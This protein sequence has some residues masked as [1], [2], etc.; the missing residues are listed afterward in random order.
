VRGGIFVATAVAQE[1][2]VGFD[3]IAL[4]NT[5]LSS[6]VRDALRVTEIMYNP[7]S[8]DTVE[9]I[10]LQNTGLAAI[11]L[12][13]VRFDEG[14]PVDGMV[15]GK[16]T[17]EP[18]E[19]I[20][21]T[22]D[23]AAFRTRYGNNARLGG[24]W[25][26]GS[27]SNSGERVLLRDA[28]GNTIHDFTYTDTAPWPASADGTG[29]SLEFVDTAGNY[30]NP[31]SWSGSLRLTGT[32]GK[33]GTS[34]APVAVDDTL[35]QP[36][37]ETGALLDVLANDTDADGDPLVITEVA[38]AASGTVSLDG[39]K[40]R[41]EPGPT[42]T[43]SDTFTYKINDGAGGVATATVTLQNTA[44]SAVADFLH[45]AW[46][47]GGIVLNVVGND[48]DPDGDQRTITAV[49]GATNGSTTTDGSTVTYTP[50]AAFSGSDSFTYTISDGHGGVATAL[51]TL[52][53]A[54]PVAA[55]DN[56]TAGSAAVTVAVL[57]ND[58]DADGDTL[59]LT[60]VTQGANGT[61]AIEGTGVV[62]TPGANFQGD[63]TFT[64]NVSD[65]HGGIA[66]GTVNVR[67]GGLITQTAAETGSQVPGAAPGTTYASLQVPAVGDEG[68][69]AWVSRVRTPGSKK[70]KTMLIGGDPVRALF[71]QGDQVP[72]LPGGTTFASFQAPVCDDEGRVV[73]MAGLAGAGVGKKDRAAI[74][75]TEPGGVTTMVA[76]LGT[77]ATGIAGAT[78][79]SFIALDASGGE[80]L[81]V[82]KT[83]GSTRTG[84]WAW[85]GQTTRLV[86]ST[87]VQITTSGGSKTVSAVSLL[88]AVPGSPG[89]DRSHRGGQV[90]LRLTFS[91]KS[92]A[93]GHAKLDGEQWTLALQAMSSQDT[94]F[95]GTWKSFGPPALGAA[96]STAA[97]GQVAN[98][99]AATTTALAVF[100]QDGSAEV[101]RAGDPATA[102]TTMVSFADPVANT[103]GAIAFTAKVSGAGIS[104]TK[105]TRLFVV[106]PGGEMTM[107]AAQG[108]P[109]GAGAGT[110][111]QK[112]V[113]YALPEGTNSEPIFLATFTGPG[114]TK[115]NNLGL[116]TRKSDGSYLMIAR[117][118]QPATGLTSAKVIKKLTLLNALPPVPG[119]A[120][121]FNA[122]RSVAYLATF[123]DGTQAVQVQRLP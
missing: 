103:D 95:G 42:F 24:Q 33:T 96:G 87:G 107:I 18:G 30:N 11:N 55:I 115:K 20:V 73:F 80:T 41:Y 99:S 8:P 43:G 72:G 6:P 10:E 79:S 65:G 97:I 77:P 116:W 108:Q 23:T 22:N 118:G 19:Y 68:C 59:S 93:I 101:I 105:A 113:S 84:V 28:D 61:T 85:D 81:Y 111:W 75:A 26:G 44:P 114:V 2:R 51:V 90:A 27:L 5:G 89:H 57:A 112:I 83:S 15:F 63:D 52:A 78:L 60:S 86:T 91:D 45:P 39:N 48:T 53:N 88:G 34:V 16:E 47:G 70:L 104:K 94:G 74:F 62:Y 7:K 110:E 117:T 102:G 56:V 106:P 4:A 58:T 29:R 100:D 32:P 66:T 54:A 38:V 46:A 121:S 119:S 14:T 71:A 76:R 35:H 98:G 21:V 123:T 40:I 92:N 50:G 31:T 9:F 120:R 109:S 64:Y 49:G 12:E 82:A 3:Y 1:V 67:N 25:T 69:L 122:A 17:L 13:G 36:I 37:V